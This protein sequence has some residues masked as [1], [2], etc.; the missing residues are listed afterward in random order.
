MPDVDWRH[1]DRVLIELVKGTGH[2]ARFGVELWGSW[3][4]RKEYCQGKARLPNFVKGRMTVWDRANKIYCSD[5]R[6]GR[7]NDRL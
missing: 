6:G 1:L 5:E 7:N 3:G 4:V 2:K